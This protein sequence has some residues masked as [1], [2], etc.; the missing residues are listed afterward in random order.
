MTHED[1]AQGS[2]RAFGATALCTTLLAALLQAPL[3]AQ[4]AV[5]ET[6][7]A[8]TA[9]ATAEPAG[10][11]ESSSSA[12]D[13]LAKRTAD[14][15]ASPMTFSLIG[16]FTTASYDL[17]GG[18]PREDSTVLKF[19]PVLPF[20]AWGV[21]NI[22]RM[23]LPYEVSGPGNGGLGDVTFFDMAV[24]GRSWGRLGVGVVASFASSASNPPSHASAGPAIGFVAPVS[25]KLSVGLFNQ[26]LFANGIG[27]SQLQP[28]V[29][30][31]LGH[32]WSLSAGDLQFVYDWE[33]NAFVSLPV[34]FQV[35][36]VQ[37]VGG[38]PLRFAVNPQYNFKDLPGADR[39]KTVLTVSL[40]VP[41]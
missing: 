13:E 37:R 30:Y 41:E 29:A 4:T 8:P 6:T 21:A 3:A 38:Q 32:G 24:F 22:L 1:P 28:I 16:D 40:L 17:A 36:K 12:A 18:V 26:N 11:G 25:R 2:D 14:P 15:T 39:F 35:G 27:I 5:L 20:K 31:Q 33:R 7:P 10:A 23:T 9:G 34:G 19:Q